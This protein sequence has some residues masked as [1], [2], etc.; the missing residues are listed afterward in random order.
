MRT[1][2]GDLFKAC[3]SGGVSRSQ[4]CLAQK[5]EG[6]FYGEKREGFR[7]V[8]IGG[9]WPG[10]PGGPARCG[11]SCVLGFRAYLTFSSWSRVRSGDKN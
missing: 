4:V 6:K 10:E 2:R 9:C 1:N 8:L 3:Y 5:E 11:A 7:C